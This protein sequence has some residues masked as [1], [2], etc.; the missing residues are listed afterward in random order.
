MKQRKWFLCLLLLAQVASAGIT[1]KIVG[2]VTDDTGMPLPGVNVVVLGE[3]RG[4]ATDFDGE[5]S[6]L[7]IA[8]GTYTLQFSSL[9]YSTLQVENVGVSVD[10]STHQDATLS[11]SAIEGETVTI[12]AEREMVQID[13]T[14]S[15]S[16]VGAKE[17]A[18]MPVTELSQ[19]VDV[20]AGVVDGHFRGGRSGEVLYLVDG[21]PVTD[22]YDGSKGVD[23][24]VS[25]VQELQVISGT[26]NA[27]YG[28]AMSGVVNTVTRDAG[29]KLQLTVSG[30][31]G[32]YLS[33]HTDEFYNIDEIDPINLSNIEL[34]FS[35]PTPLSW[36]SL[37]GS[38][39]YNDSN[40]WYTGRRL[41]SPQEAVWG[42]EIDGTQYFI[43][44]ADEVQNGYGFEMLGE[45]WFFFT[46]MYGDSTLLANVELFNALDDGAWG[47]GTLVTQ[48]DSLTALAVLNG[49]S[50]ESVDRFETASGEDTGVEDIAMNT[51]VRRS[52]QL[53][54]RAELAPGS[55]LRLMW[56]GNDR[57]YR[58]FS[59][60]WRYTPDGRLFRYSRNQ[61]ISLK[62]DQ[63]LNEET[64]FDIALSHSLSL[65]HHRLYDDIMDPRY[66]SDDWNSAESGF[67]YYDFGGIDIFTPGYTEN[68]E[69]IGFANMGGTE[70]EHF[71]RRTDTWTLKGNLTRQWGKRH[72]WKTGFEFKQHTLKFDQQNVSFNNFDIVEPQGANDNHYEQKPWEASLYLQDK[73]E[74]SDVT[75]NAGMRFDIF[76]AAAELPEDLTDPAH[77]VM[78]EVDAKMQLSPRLAIA[79]LISESGVLHFSYGMFFQRPSFEVLYRNPDYEITG[80][81]TIVGNPDLDVERTTQ[82]EIGLQQ[83]LTED[84]AMDISFYSRD[85]RDLVSTDLQIETV[86]VDKYYMF[87]NRDFGTVK[88]FVLSL[89]KRYDGGFTAGLDYT[90]QIAEANAS[91][92]EAARNALE[93]G[94]EVN[95]YLI[96][97]DWDRRH[98]LNGYAS[99]S[100]GEI[101]GLSLLGTY[102]SGL[103]YTPDPQSDDLVVGL[104]DNSGRKPDYINFDLSGWWRLPV[105]YDM[106]LNFQVKNLFDRLN[107]NSVNAATGR[108][109]YNIDWQDTQAEWVVD[110]GYWSRPR[111]VIVGFRLAL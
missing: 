9:G 19:V 1:G 34:G 36:L 69:Y 32:D 26:F 12:V 29:D 70:N 71:S 35:T 27:E 106:Q 4:A 3:P 93:G 66:V 54:L 94:G 96:P 52:G 42:L 100:R 68:A 30:Y 105:K 50:E 39:R 62:L 84:L 95:K 24:Q 107:E 85:I 63:V 75:V 37:N 13:Q 11:L 108:A 86:N 14:F 97:M 31:A 55:I 47:D 41:F 65:Y 7:N 61:L 98:T 28:Q 99:Y 53:K 23:V 51:E 109:G 22:V 56:L 44:N 43:Y 77:S 49:L 21:I 2:T 102:G 40:G 101:W 64:F 10:L 59:N 72:L 20:Q 45:D 91:S 103:P 83:Q 90:F 33:G 25:M 110:P 89:D 6:I 82:Y 81:N 38:V 57:K 58:D 88:G 60:A 17:L 16:Y 67:Y 104:L 18:V 5:Y 15:A 79:Y 92:A 8:P 111:E 87:T 76:D 46:D 73:I 78:R 74:F 48:A 80:T